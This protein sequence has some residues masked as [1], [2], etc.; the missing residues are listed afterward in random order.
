MLNRIPAK[1]IDEYYSRTGAADRKGKGKENA[2]PT[3]DTRD[4]S[5]EGEN[6][7]DA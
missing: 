5:G 7:I 6:L 2:P 4:T 3:K 1:I